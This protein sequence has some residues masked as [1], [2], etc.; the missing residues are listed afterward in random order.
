MNYF[1]KAQH[2]ERITIGLVQQVANEDADCIKKY[3]ELLGHKSLTNCPHVNQIRQTVVSWLEAKGPTFGRHLQSQLQLQGDEEFCVSWPDGVRPRPRFPCSPSLWSQ[4]QTD[5]HMDVVQGWDAK[6]LEAWA[7]TNNE[8]AV[9]STYVHDFPSLNKNVNNRNEVPFI[10]RIM[11]T[12]NGIVRNQQASSAINLE[13]PILAPLWGA[14]LSFSKC[15]AERKTPYDPQLPQTF[16]GEEFSKFVRLWTRGYDV[17]TVHRSYVVHDY[18]RPKGPNPQGWKRNPEEMKRSVMRLKTLF[19]LPGGERTAEG[20][21]KL[22]KYGLGTKRTLDQLIDF[23]GVD[24][25][26]QK[27]IGNRCIDLPY[28]PFEPDPE[29]EVEVGDIWGMAPVVS[30]GG[31]PHVPIADSAEVFT[32]QLP[33]SG[34]VAAPGAGGVAS[35]V[36]AIG[37]EEEPGS[38]SAYVAQHRVMVEALLI[39]VPMVLFV[40]LLA[41]GG[42]SRVP[43]K[44]DAK[45]A[46][47]AADVE[48]H[49][50]AAV[51]KSGALSAR[52]AHRGGGG[53]EAQK[54]V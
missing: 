22:G 9:L 45:K 26:N 2:P 39:L 20:L 21:M 51:L 43:S 25:R 50:E 36:G 7:M 5:S 27:I 12:G 3:C 54:V 1:T 42:F 38:W 28:V 52:R 4:M 46:E 49:D 10:C 47:D 40:V 29:P 35:A 23:V 15:H 34:A 30:R 18:T 37:G 8:Y 19:G 31:W 13:R 41:A 53:G 17:Y 33:S 48:S 16:D 6:L 44:V 32:G 14:G 24:L 11:W